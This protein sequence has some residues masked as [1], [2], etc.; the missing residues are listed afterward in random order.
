MELNRNILN[1]LEQSYAEAL[2][3]LE[4]ICKIPAPSNH[5]EQ[6]AA[7]CKE[8]LE[9]Q[10]AEGVYIDEALNVVLPWCCEGKD[11]IVAFLAHTDT[12]FPDMTEPMPYSTAPTV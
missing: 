2:E 4:T 12:V 8:W 10:G 5:E 7:F 1:Y 9:K 3:L 11:D 6:R